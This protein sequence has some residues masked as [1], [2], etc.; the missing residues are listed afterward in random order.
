MSN[1]KKIEFVK[2]GTREVLVARGNI[3]GKPLGKVAAFRES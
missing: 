1:R 3:I 2:P